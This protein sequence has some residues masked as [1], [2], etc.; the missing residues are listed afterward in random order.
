MAS[1]SAQQHPDWEWVLIPDFSNAAE[2]EE[3]LADPSSWYLFARNYPPSFLEQ[4]FFRVM[5]PNDEHEELWLPVTCFSPR[6]FRNS[7][8]CCDV[9]TVDKDPLHWHLSGAAAMVRKIPS[10]LVLTCSL[11]ETQLTFNMI[12]RTLAGNEGRESC[13]KEDGGDVELSMQEIIV[14]AEEF[15]HEQNLLSSENQRI[16]IVLEGL[17]H[18]FAPGTVLQSD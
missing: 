11:S 8:W 17:P 14:F 13:P 1:P 6:P 16:C 4:N 2:M 15:A 18:L 12:F 7:M 5:W 3:I 10:P 9:V